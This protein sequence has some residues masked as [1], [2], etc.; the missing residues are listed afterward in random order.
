VQCSDV[1]LRFLYSIVDEPTSGLDSH[2]AFAIIQLL[3]DMAANNTVVLLTI[4][5]P[6]SEIFFLLDSAVYMLEGRIFYQGPVQQVV[7]HFSALGYECPMNYNP[8]DFVMSLCQTESPAELE[9]KGMFMSKPLSADS[10]PIT[11]PVAPAGGARDRSGGSID[12]NP[13]LGEGTSSLIVSTAPFLTQLWWLVSRELT[14][15][16]RNKGALIGRFGVT[17]FLNFLFGLI[18]LNAGKRDNADNEAFNT[19][20]GAI[21]MVTISSMFGAAQPTMLEFPFDRPMFMREYV[22]GT[23]K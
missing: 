21:T 10:M 7:A 16:G 9:K 15:L 6:S 22:T 11:A 17:I 3:K 13:E 4:H 19:H 8:C 12:L 1:C 20:V 2:T 18:F 5:Q 14:S 23:C